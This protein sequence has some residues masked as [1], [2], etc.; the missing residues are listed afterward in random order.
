M[1]LNFQRGEDGTFAALGEVNLLRY[2]TNP[3]IQV[4]VPEEGTFQMGIHLNYFRSI[5]YDLHDEDGEYS[6]LG[7]VEGDWSLS[8][9]VTIDTSQNVTKT[10]EQEEN[11]VELSRI[12]RTGT[13]VIVEFAMPDMTKAPYNDPYND[14]AVLVYRA[15]GAP[16]PMS[17]GIT[18]PNED[19]T[20]TWYM[21][22]M[23]TEDTDLRVEVVNKN[24]DG[25]VIASFDVEG[26]ALQ[27]QNENKEDFSQEEGELPS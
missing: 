22:F 26:E 14:P 16:L 3:E 21:T 17:E 18:L 11:G 19:G 24:V 25:S 12:V 20:S 9:P 8:F 7:E 6:S 23:Y 10:M 4:D 2:R 13:H 27:F 15:D 5:D 1:N